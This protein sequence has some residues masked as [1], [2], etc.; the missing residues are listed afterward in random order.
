MWPVTGTNISDKH[1]AFVFRVEVTCTLK[2]ERESKLFKTLE[3]HTRLHCVL[4]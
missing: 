3:L 1:G 2:I 4:D